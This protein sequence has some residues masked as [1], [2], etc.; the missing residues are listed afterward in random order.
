[1]DIKGKRV[2][3]IGAS[4]GL[5]NAIGRA[6]ASEGAHL[7]L[8]ARRADLVE[9]AAK[10]AGNDAIPMTCDVSDGEDCAALV[11]RAAEALGGLDAFVFGAALGTLSKLADADAK[12]WSDIF[13]TNVT[14]AA[15]ITRAAL[16]HLA[17]SDGTALYISSISAT[18]TPPWPGLGLYI[19]SKAALERMVAA[20]SCEHPEVRFGCLV[21]GPADAHPDAPS[22]FGRTWDTQLA[23]EVGTVWMQRGLMTGNQIPPADLCN[24]VIN[25]LTTSARLS[26]VVIEPR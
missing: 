22:E 11:N 10:Q 9:A 24:Q 1:V 17:E 7:V 18:H 14:G 15:Q 25:M 5:G 23:Q 3:V 16:P 2:L 6:L 12:Q 8:S 21:V 20:W 19:V 13:A 4:S 26:T